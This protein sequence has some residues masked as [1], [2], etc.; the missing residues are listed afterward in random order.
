[1]LLAYRSSVQIVLG[2]AT[3]GPVP[4]LLKS[5]RGT[6]STKVVSKSSMWPVTFMK[7]RFEL[8]RKERFAVIFSRFFV[9]PCVP[10]TWRSPEKRIL[11][12]PVA[13]VVFVKLLSEPAVLFIQ[14]VGS[15]KTVCK[16]TE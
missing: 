16:N 3:K 2:H 8:L 14:C 12:L 9:M 11:P 13:N 10:F 4:V 7:V 15:V 5:T 1:M 6:G